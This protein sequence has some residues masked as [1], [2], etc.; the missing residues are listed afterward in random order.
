ME[1]LGAAAEHGELHLAIVGAPLNMGSGWRDSGKRATTYMRLF[2]WPMG[3]NDQY[4]QVN[5][6]N[7]LKIVDYGD[8]AIDNDSTERSMQHVRDI[9]RE[10]GRRGAGCLSEK[11]SDLMT[12]EVVTCERA[13]KAGTRIRRAADDLERLT[14]SGGDLAD[15]QPIGIRMP[16]DG[17]NLADDHAVQT[18]AFDFDRIDGERASP[19]ALLDAVCTLPVVAPRRLV[20][21]RHPEAQRGGGDGVGC[22]LCRGLGGRQ[23]RE[24]LL[25][26][27]C[28]RL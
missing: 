28:A 14:A 2:G 7:T 10:I 13:D 1:H 27:L 3:D 24:R 6:G 25:P 9:V 19:G 5:A 12:R 17:E 26:D 15:A 8:I 21:L 4:V 11:V 23:G 18:F 20:W 16:C 22:A